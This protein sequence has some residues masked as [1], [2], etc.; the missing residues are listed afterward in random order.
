MASALQSLVL[1]LTAVTAA[2]IFLPLPA[3][4]LLE[5]REPPPPVWPYAMYK[6]SFTEIVPPRNLSAHLAFT[7]HHPEGRFGT[8]LAGGPVIDGEGNFY[9]SGHDNFRKLNSMGEQQWE[10]RPPSQTN[11]MPVLGSS[12]VLGNDV[13]GHA[14]ALDM[15]T[16][17][18][19]WVTEVSQGS[20][21]D[22]GYPAVHKGLFVMATEPGHTN[23]QDGGNVRIVALNE[24]TGDLVW[25]LR[26]S[27]PVWNF[28][29]LF[30][31]DDHF[32]AMDFTGSMMKVRLDSGE[33]VWHTPA[34]GSAQ[35]FSDG[36][37]VMGDENVYTCS[38]PGLSTGSEG[39]MGIVRALSI[40]DG[41]IVWEKLLPQPCNS[42][43]AFGP[44]NGKMAVVVT[45]GSF[46]GAPVMHGSLM[47]LDAATGDE[48]WRF[49]APPFSNIEGLARGDVEGY[50]VR[51]A[52]KDPY[53]LPICAPAHWGAPIITG[54]GTVYAIRMDGLLYAVRAPTVSEAPA[55]G[56]D[57]HSSS[58]VEVETFDAL[59]CALHG[60]FAFAPGTM[61]LQTC[62]S[63]WVFKF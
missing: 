9:L 25:N 32:L 46:P 63:L 7:W 13:G 6:S 58:G 60:S 39:E 61:A 36:G 14:F 5:E 48:L 33:L 21:G 62:D 2:S 31:A 22:S 50:D 51:A 16:G 44:I 34:P 49:Q 17:W 57:F 20:G 37:A 45:P 42:Y 29:P 12:A 15:E 27:I 1:A 10:F 41:S 35:S 52:S 28:Q 43:P 8:V 53:V 54:D 55:T 56:I 30:T 4:R 38:N 59:G 24:T 18:P 40:A 23:T 3:Q 19:L 26:V 47:A 11:N